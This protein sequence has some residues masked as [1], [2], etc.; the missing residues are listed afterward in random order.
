M[1]SEIEN[2]TKS[3][4]QA[5]I[6]EAINET[7]QYVENLVK[8]ALNQEVNEHGGKP[9]YH[10]DIKQPYLAY[11]VG[12]NIRQLARETVREYMVNHQDTIKT[13]ILEAMREDDFAECYAGLLKEASETWNL[14]INLSTDRG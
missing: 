14:Q 13:K 3:L 9:S 8:A 2:I 5:K 11:L 12:E 4:I 1:D 6:L 7:P 10:S